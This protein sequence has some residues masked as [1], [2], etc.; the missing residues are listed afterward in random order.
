[1]ISPLCVLTKICK[2]FRLFYTHLLSF[3][4]LKQEKNDSSCI[5]ISSEL[6]ITKMFVVKYYLNRDVFD[7]Y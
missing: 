7:Q 4:F 5:L 2:S 3:E 6:D 1:M